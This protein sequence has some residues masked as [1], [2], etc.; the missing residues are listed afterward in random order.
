MKSGVTKQQLINSLEASLKLTRAGVE[1]LELV[2]EEL[3]TIHYESGGSKNVNI[4][5]DSGIAII[6][7]V[8]RSIDY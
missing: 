4:A 3:V 5:C 7:D 2:N 8:T 1:S 6:R